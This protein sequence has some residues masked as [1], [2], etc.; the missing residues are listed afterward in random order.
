MLKRLRRRLT[1]RHKRELTGA[2][3]GRRYP[4]LDPEFG[5]LFEA[6]RHATM[7]SVERLYALYNAVEYVVKADISGDFVECGV[8][9]GGSLMMMALALQHFGDAGRRICAFDT[10]EGMPPPG[11]LDIRH[12]SG[13]TAGALLAK[14]R[15]SETSLI[16][17]MAPIDIVRANMA[18]T[19][20]RSELVSFHRGLVEQTLPSQAPERIAV[21]RLDTDWYESTKH[22]LVH[23]YPRLAPGGVLIL[24]DYG[25]YR[26]AR[27]ATD[28]FFSG[29]AGILLNRIDDSG[30]IGIK[31]A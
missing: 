26:G 25:Y 3:L 11:P 18:A 1:G 17:A 4:D 29:G 5:P 22:E 30:R 20:Y 16:W 12:A 24:D 2:N 23:L 28:E 15:R 21:L 31:P 27:Q 6:C 19:G 13:E 9:R 14:T 10:F 8:W 7:T